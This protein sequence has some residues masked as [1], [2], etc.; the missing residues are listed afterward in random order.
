MRA[1]AFSS[2]DSAAEVAAQQGAAVIQQ[3][4]PMHGVPKLVS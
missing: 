1:E 3:C 2:E 4:H